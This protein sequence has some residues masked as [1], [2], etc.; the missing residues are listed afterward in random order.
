MPGSSRQD[1]LE[2]ARATLAARESWRAIFDPPSA[3]SSSPEPKTRDEQDFAA[4][5]P[6][7]SRPVDKG[8]T[9]DQSDQ[10]DQRSCAEGVGVSDDVAWRVEAMRPQ[11]RPGPLFPFLVS[12]RD[13]LDAPGHCLSCGDPVGP[14]RLYRC[15]PCVRAAEIVI[16]EAWEGRHRQRLGASVENDDDQ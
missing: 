1:Y 9:C 10:S 4:S 7:P 14:D 16:N 8:T 13:F 3:S 15:S 5:W 11:V 2:R 6:D 12:R